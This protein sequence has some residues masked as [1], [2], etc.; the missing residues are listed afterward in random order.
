[1]LKNGAGL[2]RSTFAEGVAC[3]CA[4]PVATPRLG[5]APLTAPADHAHR[6]DTRKPSWYPGSRLREP[7]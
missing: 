4:L 7:E 2:A 3:A 5:E 1:M 6:R